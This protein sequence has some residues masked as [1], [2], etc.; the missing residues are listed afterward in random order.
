MNPTETKPEARFHEIEDVLHL[1]LFDEQWGVDRPVYEVVDAERGGEVEVP[2]DG[3][4]LTPGQLS[5]RAQTHVLQQ[6]RITVDL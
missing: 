1:E 3:V 2:R 6:Y 5:Q 4:C